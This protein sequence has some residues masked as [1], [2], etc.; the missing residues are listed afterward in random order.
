MNSIVDDLILIKYLNS[1]CFSETY[2]FIKKG[3]NQFYATKRISLEIID[4]EQIFKENINNEIMI[5]NQ[6]NHPNIVKL[7]D[8]KV[9]K[10]Y[11]YLV[12]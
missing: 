5:L 7:Y 6:I 11:V 8:V 12:M 10:D 1:G 9:K 4:Q 3:S 2:L